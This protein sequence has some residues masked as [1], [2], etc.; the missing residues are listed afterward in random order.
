MHLIY[1]AYNICIDYN[2][3]YIDVKPILGGHLMCIDMVSLHTLELHSIM[4][5]TRSRLHSVGEMLDVI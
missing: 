3:Y 2:I 4:D 5:K 1:I